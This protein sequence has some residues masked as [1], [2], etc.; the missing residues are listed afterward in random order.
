MAIRSLLQLCLLSPLVSVATAKPIIGKRGSFADTQ[1]LSDPSFGPVPGESPIFSTYYGVEAPFPGNLRDA[2]LPTKA[3]PP[4]EDDVVWQNL[5]SAEWVIFDFYQQAVEAFNE[6]A[7]IKAGMP[8]TTYKRIQEI[9]N[10]E[11]GH[12]RIFQNQISPTSVK[13]GACEHQFPFYDPISFLALVTVLEVSSMAFLTGLVRDAKLPS[14]QAAMLSIAETEARHEVWS[15]I[16]IWKTNPFGGPSDTVFPYANQI[17][18]TTNAFI[19]P[20]SCPPENPEYPSPRQGLPALSAAKDTKSLT[21]GSNIGL[22]FTDPT[23][24]PK[25][26]SDKEYYAVFFHGLSNISVPI[27]T[28]CWPEKEIRVT[29]PE[30]FETKGVIAAVVADAPGAPTKEN[31]VA[32]PGIILEQ[33][34]ALATKLL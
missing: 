31:V 6:T 11:A 14:S 25:F 2:V 4:G 23:N 5:L 18:D 19:V 30:Q 24:Q 1:K 22:S 33:P 27:E 3:G 12:L 17:L 29:I 21:P 28:S 9:R 15:L 26:D 8:N 20:G 32:G 10:N 16:E 34:T 13:P 7:F